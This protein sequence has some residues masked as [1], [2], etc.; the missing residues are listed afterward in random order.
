[1]QMKKSY[2]LILGA[3]LSFIT[4]SSFV[5]SSHTMEAK[6]LTFIPTFKPFI[7]NIQALKLKGIFSFGFNKGLMSKRLVGCT[8]ISAACEHEYQSCRG[9]LDFFDQDNHELLLQAKNA[10]IYSCDSPPEKC[11]GLD[12]NPTEEVPQTYFKVP[13]IPIPDILC[14]GPAKKACNTATGLSGTQT[15]RS[16]DTTT[17]EWNFGVCIAEVI[18]PPPTPQCQGA[19]PACPSGYSGSYVCS[20]G[21]WLNQCVAPPP[22]QCS[23]NQPQCSPG[24]LGNYVCQNGNWINYCYLPSCSGNA[25]TCPAGQTGFYVC[26]NGA[27]VSQCQQGSSCPA[28]DP[29]YKVCIMADGRYGREY[30]DHCNE[31]TGDWVYRPCNVYIN[32]Q[33]TCTS[34]TYTPWSSC[35]SGEQSRTIVTR[36]PYGCAGGSPVTI[37]TC[38]SGAQPSCPANWTGSYTCSNNYWYPTCVPPGPDVCYRGVKYRIYQNKAYAPCL[39]SG[40]ADNVNGQSCNRILNT[41]S[42]NIWNDYNTDTLIRSY[43][44]GMYNTT[45][46]N[47]CDPTFKYT[48]C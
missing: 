46:P 8:E 17:G 30:A 25:P 35:S 33:P 27:W 14:T 15:A 42:V 39:G 5:F 41:C 24:Y 43:I 12:I 4:I 9:G 21:N 19:Q 26:Q 11:F 29:D 2:R 22:P 6:A 16:C 1:M 10:C 13:Y 37:Q 3:A 36:A 45:I 44:D 31:T 32:L 40:V 20:N 23:P 47:S 7:F 48:Q 38:C 34:F 28:L 18:I